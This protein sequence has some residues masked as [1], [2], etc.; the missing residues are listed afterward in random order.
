METEFQFVMMKK[1]QQ[2]SHNKSLFNATQLCP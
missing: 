2:W 1:Y